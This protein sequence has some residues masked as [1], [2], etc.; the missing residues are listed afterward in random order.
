METASSKKFYFITRAFKKAWNIFPSVFKDLTLNFGL[1]YFVLSLLF[2]LFLAQ[3]SE[4]AVLQSFI[5]LIPVFIARCF[6]AFL[7]PYY[8]YKKAFVSASAPK[9]WTFIS[10]TVVPFVLVSIKA[11]F[12]LLFFTIL[13]IIPGLYKMF[14]LFFINESV[15]FESGTFRT[16]LRKSDQT[17]RGFF[18]WIILFFLLTIIL[19]RLSF[20]FQTGPL[21]SIL[22]GFLLSFLFIV[23]HFYLSCFVIMWKNLFYFE[24]KA[25]KDEPISL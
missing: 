16:A 3:K 24:I 25:S 22:P 19:M 23:F 12:V 21:K 11:T 14:R 17:T 6:T 13:L 9:F 4:S 1:Y 7:V 8:T 5:L 18:W 20:I 2:I 15:F 10:R